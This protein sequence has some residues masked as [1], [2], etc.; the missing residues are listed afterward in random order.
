MPE[1]S[2]RSALAWRRG[3]EIHQVFDEAHGCCAAY[4]RD[5]L[6]DFL[7]N[8]SANAIFD[9][10]RRR[11]VRSHCR[12]RTRAR[13]AGWSRPPGRRDDRSPT[14]RPPRARRA[15]RP[16]SARV[17]VG[18]Q[19]AVRARRS[20]WLIR[21]DGPEQGLKCASGRLE[22]VLV[23]LPLDIGRIAKTLLRTERALQIL[24]GF[25]EGFLRHLDLRRSSQRVSMMNSAK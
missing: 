9:P 12:Q 7:D 23:H 4:A 8:P 6:A 21:W 15:S 11:L 10:I 20:S 16:T 18:G 22:R 17:R 1:Q 25:L 13:H 19:L 14:R 24:L 2:E 3:E 5:S